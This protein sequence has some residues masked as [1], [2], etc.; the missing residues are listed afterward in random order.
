LPSAPIFSPSTPKD[1]FQ[2]LPT[3]AVLTFLFYFPLAY[4]QSSTY[5]IFRGPF[6]FCSTSYFSVYLYPLQ[7]IFPVTPYSPHS[8]LYHRSSYPPKD[9]FFVMYSILPHLSLSWTIFHFHVPHLVLSL[10]SVSQ[11]QS[12]CIQFS[13]YYYY[14]YYYCIFLYLTR[15][16]PFWAIIGEK[17][18]TRENMYRRVETCS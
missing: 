8:V 7:Y 15:F 11:T 13:Y 2:F 1:I 6:L 5:H 17:L 10:L 16:S 12:I 9:F 4:S 14:Y 18:N 3:I